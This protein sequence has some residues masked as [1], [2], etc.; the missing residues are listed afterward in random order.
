MSQRDVRAVDNPITAV[1]DLAE[2]VSR[3]VPRVRKLVTYASVFIGAWLVISFF[4]MIALLFSNVI[5]SAVVLVLF[6]IGIF[7][8]ASLR[9]L[10]D[11]MRYYALRHMAI[12]RVRNEDP[13]VYVPKGDTAVLRLMEHLRHRNPSMSS[14]IASGHYQAPSIQKGASSLFY[15][16]DAYLSSRAGAL[17]KALGVGYPGYQLFVKLFTASPRPEDLEALRKAAE[18]VSRATKLP[19]SRVIA[20]WTRDPAIDL[21]EE[22]FAYLEKAVVHFCHRG[23]RYA[24]SM[25]L[26]IEN[27]DGTY[28][29]IPYVAEGPYFS[30]PRA[31]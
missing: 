17:W 21:S 12:V 23:K 15:N 7:A 13:I 1:F 27:A 28:E 24:S 16:F 6:I 18:D 31:Q 25:E 20:L 5:L 26:V 30:A 4:L 29:F 3:E 8:L 9:N 10:G 2:E 22:A 11:F 19:P 14:A